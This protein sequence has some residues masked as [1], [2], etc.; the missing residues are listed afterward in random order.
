VAKAN[1]AKSG[2]DLVNRILAG[3]QSA[4]EELVQHYSRGVSFIINRATRNRSVTEDL[5]QE[6][7]RILLE[8]IRQGSVR[9]PEKLPGFISSLA[10]NLAIDYFRRKPDP[11]RQISI[12]SAEQFLDPAPSPLDQLLQKEKAEIARQVLKELSSDRDREILSRFY[13]AEED[14]EQICADLGLTSLQFNQVLYRA[15]QRYKERYEKRV[16]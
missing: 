15:R 3:D 13:I 1:N 12:K 14:K 11:E 4:E 16:S 7:F 9:E 5:S 2:S 8:K 10:R 6:T